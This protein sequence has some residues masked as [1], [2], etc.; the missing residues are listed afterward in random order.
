LVLRYFQALLILIW[1]SSV[2]LAMLPFLQDAERR[3]PLPV[4]FAVA[5]TIWT[6]IAL[7]IVELPLRWL[8]S[9]SKVEVRKHSMDRLRKLD[10]AQRFASL[11][12][13]LCFLA[14]VSVIAA[15]VVE[16]GLLLN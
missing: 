1:T 8:A 3:F 4:V 13:R 10:A 11:T 5:Y 2:T 16:I 12:R 14:L 7:L 6:A 15:F 9:A